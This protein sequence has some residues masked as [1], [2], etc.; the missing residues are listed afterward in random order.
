M[1]EHTKSFN[2]RGTI[3]ELG[4]QFCAGVAGTSQRFPAMLET[5]AATII[6]LP[7]RWKKVMMKRGQIKFS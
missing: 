7:G 5:T 1:M 2:N 4:N 6:E 3:I